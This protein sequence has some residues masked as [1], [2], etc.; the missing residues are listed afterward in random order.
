[1]ATGQG[2]RQDMR[3]SDEIACPATPPTWSAARA[4]RTWGSL[5]ARRSWFTSPWWTPREAA[6]ETSGTCGGAPLR[7]WVAIPGAAAHC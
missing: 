6:L 1:M 3:V 4:S 5:D 2:P 7:W